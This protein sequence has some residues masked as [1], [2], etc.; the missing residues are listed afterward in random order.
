M[1]YDIETEILKSNYLI[2]LTMLNKKSSNN[3]VKTGNENF[4]NLYTLTKILFET[5]I[6]LYGNVSEMENYIFTA[7][8]PALNKVSDL[9]SFVLFALEFLSNISKKYSSVKLSVAR[10]AYLGATNDVVS[11]LSSYISFQKNVINSLNV[12]LDD[13]EKVDISSYQNNLNDFYFLQAEIHRIYSILLSKARD[14]V[15]IIYTT[16]K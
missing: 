12:F 5:I 9:N 2:Y 6:P 7:M 16:L 13:N 14:N 15:I 8:L 1:N 4:D 10:A 11:F 3:I